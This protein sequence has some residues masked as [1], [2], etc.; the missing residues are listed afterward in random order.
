M[1]DRKDKSHSLQSFRYQGRDI[2]YRS[3]TSD[4]TLIYEILLK[5]EYKSE[6]YIPKQVNPKIILDIGANI[7]ITSI[8]LANR[9]PKAK[10]YSF[11]PFPDNYEILKKNAQTYNN[12]EVFNFGLGSKEGDFDIYLSEDSENFGGVSFYPEAGGVTNTATF[13]CKIKNINN[14]LKEIDITSI[15]LIKI[16]TEGAEFDILTSLDSEILSNVSWI[17]GELH[18]NKDFELL[19]YLV[20]IGLKIGLNKEIDNRLF[21]F[22]A[23]KSKIVS[24]MNGKELKLLNNI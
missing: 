12:I 5:S 21:M 20:K 3:N 16:D 23:G 9:F 15:D 19:D 10:I 22:N 2:Y 13:K 7:G 17:T 4:M 14:I 24:M 1:R 8:Y 18:G 6:Y 11:E